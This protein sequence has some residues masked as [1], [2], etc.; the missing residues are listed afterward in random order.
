MAAEGSPKY[1]KKSNSKSVHLKMKDNEEIDYVDQLLNF[2]NIETNKIH[3][4]K[5]DNEWIVYI[6]SRDELEKLR[7]IDIFKLSK[8]RK[9][10]FDYLLSDYKRRQVKKGNVIK[11]YLNAV[12]K[13]EEIT[14]P[15]LAKDIRRD[16]T[17]VINVLRK[18][19]KQGFLKAYRSKRTGRAYVFSLTNKGKYYL[20]G[21]PKL[22][23][24]ASS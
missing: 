17:R 21:F 1:N 5:S 24:F 12:N 8:K 3:Y 7:K 23:K 10:K 19:Q 6:S 14:A 15:K 18:L 22:S 16:R 4:S 9:E 11:F 13:F 2:L 20:M